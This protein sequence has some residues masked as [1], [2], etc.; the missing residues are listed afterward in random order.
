MAEFSLSQTF[1]PKCHYQRLNKNLTKKKKSHTKSSM[2]WPPIYIQY[3]YIIFL[4]L[5]SCLFISANMK[6]K[7]VKT[8]TSQKK[9][10]V[11]QVIVIH[12]VFNGIWLKF[13]AHSVSQR[14]FFLLVKRHIWDVSCLFMFYHKNTERKIE[15]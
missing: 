1:N 9:K 5:F 7:N 15:R 4:S 12:G 6:H 2:V 3:I 14:F 8:R 10:H 11:Y 13:C